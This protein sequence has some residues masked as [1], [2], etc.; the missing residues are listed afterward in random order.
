M[1]AQEISRALEQ[2]E[3]TR[4]WFEWLLW[5]RARYIALGL[6]NRQIPRTTKEVRS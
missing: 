3:R 6:A 2:R 5:Q 1:T 4:A